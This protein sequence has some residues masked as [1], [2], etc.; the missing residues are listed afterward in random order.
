MKRAKMCRRSYCVAPGDPP[1][2]STYVYCAVPPP[3][4]SAACSM[5]S[6]AKPLGRSM[7]RGK[8][9]LGL[10]TLGGS[11]EWITGGSL[12]ADGLSRALSTRLQYRNRLPEW[13]LPDVDE[14]TR[15]KLQPDAIQKTT[16]PRCT[17]GPPD[18]RRP[19][20]EP[21]HAVAIA[22]VKFWLLQRCARG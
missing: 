1:G 4:A 19:V 16:L 7:P 5:D 13:M 15:L 21:R 8:T 14:P 2:Q 17:G 6:N 22:I 18:P 12:A 9:A 11:C 10:L 20:N 3:T